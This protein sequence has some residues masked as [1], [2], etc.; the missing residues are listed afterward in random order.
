M[1]ARPPI[2]LLQLV[3]EP[4]PTFRA[5]V[6]VLFGKYLP[7]NG[8]LCDV[9]GKA[10]AAPLTDS[11]FASQRRP[12]SRA[13]RWRQELAYLAL[14]LRA[15]FHAKHGNCDVIQVRDMV[16]MGLLAMCVARLKGLPFVYWMSFLMNEG[17]IGRARAEIAAG[18]GW[19][20]RIVL[21]KGLIEK[22]LLH[23]FV[24][25]GAD[26][27]FVQ[28]D[29]MR[30]LLIGQ[31]VPAAKLTP[32][33]MGVDMEQ[34]QT[35]LPAQILPEWAGRPTLAY[36]GTLDRSRQ[37]EQVLEALALVRRRYP[38]ASLLLIGDS[39]TPADIVKL[40]DHAK[41]LGLADAVRVTGWLP[42]RDA[43]S[44]LVGAQA[45]ISYIPRGALYDISS[46][47]KLLEYLALGMPSVGN[48]SPDQVT[49]L[50]G[51]GAG[52]LCESTPAAMALA[53]E[54][55]FDAPALARERAARGPDF[56]GQARSYR[57]IAAS[58][59]DAY[60]RLVAGRS[61]MSH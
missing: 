30:Q 19:R 21:M 55:I 9:V 47:T 43:W 52:W 31:G 14:C 58:L 10:S 45:A 18:G 46:P 27:V 7:R 15:L 34:L 57:V 42:S 29:A 28:S 12:A 44:L 6:A 51:S 13:S 61:T 1:N 36:L 37:L 3:P 17:R 48:D 22:F 54:E 26:H 16:S 23:R 49:V 8:V 50:E 53:I 5:D 39:P 25:S 59:A 4:L 40:L 35:A 32:V 41:Q 11:G 56:I 24:L 38:L 2:R 20:Y 33:P 60:S